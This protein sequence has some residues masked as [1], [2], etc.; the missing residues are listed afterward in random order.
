LI[1]DD[2]E[3]RAHCRISGKYGHS[4]FRIPLQPICSAYAI[5]KSGRKK[6]S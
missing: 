4:V 5:L 2:V 1:S 3:W 6:M